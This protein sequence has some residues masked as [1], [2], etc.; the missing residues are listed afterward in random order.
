[1]NG[2]HHQ[3]TWFQRSGLL[4]YIQACYQLC[5]SFKF[6]VKVHFI[7]NDGKSQHKHDQRMEQFSKMAPNKM[8]PGTWQFWKKMVLHVRLR[9]MAQGPFHSLARCT[10]LLVSVNN[11]CFP[12]LFSMIAREFF[13]PHYE[14]VNMISHS[15]CSK[16]DA[17]P[18]VTTD[19]FS[20]VSYFSS[21]N[22]WN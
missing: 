13:F 18:N 4:I 14:N 11:I 8:W 2:I 21:E 15:S 10:Q 17:N 6:S 19:H 1:M 5:G 3:Q 7:H 16:K 9:V 22:V 12:S 20:V